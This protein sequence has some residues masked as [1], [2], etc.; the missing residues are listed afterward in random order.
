LY[1]DQIV[2]ERKLRAAKHIIVVCDF[3]RRFLQDKYPALYG[4]IEHKIH[5]HHLGIELSE[6]AYTPGR[7]AFDRVIAVGHFCKAKGFDV[8]IRAMRCLRSRGITVEVDFVG[9]GPELAACRKLARQFALSDHVRFLGWLS[10]DQVREK[11]ARAAVLVHPST[12]LGD[13][14]PTVIKEAMSL[15]TAVVASGVAGIPELLD[16]GNC[17]VLVEPENPEK[18]ADG[19]AKVVLHPA[20]RIQLAERARRRA[21]A[22]FDLW[23]NGRRLADL[24]AGQSASEAT[25]APAVA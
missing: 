11:I 16:G 19:I 18:L 22:L 10:P 8:L 17:G 12:G 1:R 5:L 14:V 3:N 24:L 4:E 7:Q 15:G 6:Y 9:D 2:L 13:A 20:L 21:E 25:R 23:V